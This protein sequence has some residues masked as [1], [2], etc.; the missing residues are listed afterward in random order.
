MIGE[1]LRTF[2]YFFTKNLKHLYTIKNIILITKI[3]RGSE[4]MNMD[5]EVYKEIKEINEQKKRE[6][7]LKEMEIALSIIDKYNDNDDF[8]EYID[9]NFPKKIDKLQYKIMRKF[10]NSNNYDSQH[11]N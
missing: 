11:D 3:K 9:K 6:N 10:F 8:K 2:F 5:F 7:E 4:N 1:Y